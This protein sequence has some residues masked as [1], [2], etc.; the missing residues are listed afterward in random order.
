MI[1]DGAVETYGLIDK[2]DKILVG[3]SGGADSVCLLHSLWTAC[4]RYGAHIF[5]AHINH[6]LRGES[7]E[8]DERFCRDMCERLGVPFFVKHADVRG[9]ARERGISEETAGREVRYAFF[10]E[11]CRKYEFDKIATAH[12]KN[13]LAETVVM[14][15]IRGAGI[16]GLS[17]IPPVRGNIIRPLIDT[18]RSEIEQ[19]CREHGLE[20]VTDET[21]LES[22]YRRNKIRLELIP[23]IQKEF[24][25]GFINS[26]AQNAKSI[27][28][29]CE[30]LENVADEE[31][32]KRVTK[33]K[34]GFCI[35]IEPLAEAV[36]SRIFMRMA[37]ECGA[38]DIAGVH[39]R[40]VDML[41]QRGETGKS[42]N[43]PDGV[44]ARTAYGVMYIEKAYSEADGFEYYIKVGQRT[45]IPEAGIAVT[46]V[47]D[48]NGSF[49]LDG[50]LCVRSRRSGDIFYP[51]GMK[52]RKKVKDYYVN[53]KIPSGERMTI[54]LLTCGGEI[55]WI[56]GRRRDRRFFGKGYSVLTEKL[57]DIK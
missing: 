45:P 27:A 18:P 4:A 53:E 12:H 23:Y 56:I 31:Y 43:L 8:R 32:K 1:I 15:F 5:A 35:R 11:L 52:G 47:P 54:P 44:C 24:N 37:A 13:D 50:E 28:A 51:A 20:F 17:G 2:G 42:V 38:S 34:N 41:W 26:V 46:V 14:N 19:Y 6:G 3:F 57:D 48:E 33:T 29:D 36:R 39:I 16:N 9:Y 40:A 10:D 49:R 55:A 7:A 25:S 21:N 30:F 22:V